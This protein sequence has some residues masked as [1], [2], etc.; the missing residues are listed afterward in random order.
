MRAVVDEQGG[1]IIGSG[2]HRLRVDEKQCNPTYVARCLCGTWNERF[3]KGAT[4]QR[5]DL[6]ELE[7]P[8]IPLPEQE[9]LVNALR[10]VEQLAREAVAVAEAAA[11]AAAA[12]LDAV[13]YDA[14]IGG[15]R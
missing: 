1:R 4:I 15:D 2:V 6:R 10:E 11:A 13:R 7:I 14:P 3:K 8:L 9:R 5:V 12:I